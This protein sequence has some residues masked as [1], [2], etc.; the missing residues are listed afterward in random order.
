MVADASTREQARGVTLKVL[1][2]LDHPHGGRILRVR[3]SGGD[4]LS[5]RSLRGRTLLAQGPR[6]EESSAKVLGFALTAGNP[7][8]RWARHGRADLHV[9]E[10][11]GRPP[12]S[13]Q[14][15]L[16]LD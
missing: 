12:I 4:A 3:V 9:E 8:K 15:R 14:W 10:E 5:A 13:I 6:G 16:R 11:E 2:A 7:S 1:D